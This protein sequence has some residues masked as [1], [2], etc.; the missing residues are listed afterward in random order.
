MILADGELDEGWFL[1]FANVIG[2]LHINS[3]DLVALEFELSLVLLDDG[4]RL[5]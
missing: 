3:D 4:G 1:I 5:E 2:I